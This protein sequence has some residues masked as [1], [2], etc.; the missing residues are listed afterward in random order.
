MGN[1]TNQTKDIRNTGCQQSM[2]PVIQ[3]DLNRVKMDLAE[4]NR[5]SSCGAVVA[6]V[7]E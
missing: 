1:V 3:R 4:K 2:Q 5:C 7:Y 6:G